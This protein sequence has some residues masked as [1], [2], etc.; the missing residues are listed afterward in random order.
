MSIL[1]RVKRRVLRYFYGTD[2][3]RMIEQNKVPDPEV[4]L[5]RLQK[6]GFTPGVIYDVGAY[7]GDFTAMCSAIWPT[8]KIHMFEALP[9]KIPAL[10]E[11][12]KGQPVVIN[13][14]VVGEEEGTEVAFYADETASSVLASGSP[15]HEKAKVYQKMIRLDQYI[16][17]HAPAPNFLKVDAQGYESYILRGCG[18]TLRDIDVLLVECN[19][20][21]VY[22]EVMLASD[23]IGYLRQFGFVV[24]DICEIHRRPLDHCLFQIDFLF[25]KEESFL[26]KDKRWDVND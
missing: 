5:K 26:R 10:K 1:H 24:Y 23:L 17:A 25:V 15:E 19:F 22:K 2:L 3:Q 11:R 8:A 13:E 21:E 14:C 9:F 20:I 7:H 18:E 12:F 4:S 6:L 16:A